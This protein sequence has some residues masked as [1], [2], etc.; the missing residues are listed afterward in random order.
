MLAT[1]RQPLYVILENDKTMETVKSSVV[2]KGSSGGRDEQV[3]QGNYS[4][5]SYN[6]GYYMCV[7][8]P[9]PCDAQRQESTL[10]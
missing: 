1:V 7:I 10:T 6:D 5:W 3:K 2:A 9:Y 4:V 8:C